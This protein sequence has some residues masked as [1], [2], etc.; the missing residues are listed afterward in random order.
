MNIKLAR[1]DEYMIFKVHGSIERTNS[2]S[3]LKA[4]KRYAEVEPYMAID[5]TNVNFIDSGGIAALVELSRTLSAR[6]ASIWLYRMNP[7]IIRSLE[8]TH[9]TP[10]FKKTNLIDEI[11]EHARPHELRK[12]RATA[13]HAG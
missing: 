6:G 1:H 10:F 3:F 11:I 5:M 9:V 4:M 7:D 2:A 13:Y 12:R 8:N